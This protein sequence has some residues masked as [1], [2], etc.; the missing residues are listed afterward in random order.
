MGLSAACPHGTAVCNDVYTDN[1]V[2]LVVPLAVGLAFLF[3]WPLTR[4]LPHRPLIGWPLAVIGALLFVYVY[5]A[6]IN[7][8]LWPQGTFIG[9]FISVV[10]IAIARG[11]TTTDPNTA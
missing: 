1:L 7:S 11:R 8:V 3:A 2:W 5:V 10:G 4:F 6:G 9:F